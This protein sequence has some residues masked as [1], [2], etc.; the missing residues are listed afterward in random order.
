M[1]QGKKKERKEED[2]NSRLGRKLKAGFLHVCLPGHR[3]GQKMCL[4]ACTRVILFAQ[5]AL[6]TVTMGGCIE[7]STTAKEKKEV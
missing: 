3:S 1:E 7:K 2:T 5:Q 6:S 4:Y